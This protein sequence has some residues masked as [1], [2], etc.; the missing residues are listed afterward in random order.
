VIV[1]EADRL[2]DDAEN[3][4]LK[5]LEEPPTASV[6]IL[7][8]SRPE[9]LL[10]TVR[11]RCSR[12]RFG[13]LVAA[14]VAR[15]LSERQGYETEEAHASA[16]VADGSP[17]RALEAASRAYRDARTAALSA[18][19]TAAAASSPR[20]RLQAAASLTAGK[21]S[22]TGEREELAT[23]IAM[24]ASLLRDLALVSQGGSAGELAN[25][26]LEADLHELGVSFGCERSL[27]A[28]A[29][30]DRAVGALR[31]NA[32]PKVVAAW[33]SVHL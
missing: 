1:D 22:S 27:R 4:L 29:A 20:A 21:P 32:S 26:D 31:R 23:R 13:R 10:A 8:T 2:T 15:I 7:V 5:S 6:F 12:L 14:D 19:R 11:S 25:G 30:A 9:T 3:A 33:L 24:L 16:A 18:L 17:G 28:F